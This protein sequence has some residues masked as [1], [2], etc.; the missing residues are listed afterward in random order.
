MFVLEQ[1]GTIRVF[2]TDTP[3]TSSTEFLNIT[4][5]VRSGGELGLLGFAFDP[6]YAANGYVYVNYTAANPLRTVIARF[7]ASDTQP[8]RAD[9]ASRTVILE[10]AQ[11][12]SNHNGGALAF[13]PDGYLYIATGD[14]GSGGDPQRFGQNLNT[15]LG[16]ILRIDVRRPPA[17]IPNDNPFANQLNKRGEIWLYGLRNPWRF[18]FD[19]QTGD[20]WIGD[21]GQNAWEEVDVIPAGTRGTNLGWNTCEGA[22]AY[23]NVRQPCTTGLL[24]I[25]EYDHSVGSSVIGGYVYRGGLFPQLQ[26]QYLFSDFYTREIWALSYNRRFEKTGHARIASMPSGYSMSS[27]GE[28]PRGEI[29]FVGMR[30]SSSKL[31]KLQPRAATPPANFPRKLS[32]TGLFLNT[33][34][35]QPHADLLSYDVNVPLWSDS[36]LK[37][38]WMASL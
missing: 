8:D 9:P 21:V 37:K 28:D 35:L 10:F 29:L 25:H 15:L 7:K 14:G 12:Y 6:H 13:G 22:H 38:R 27:M 23:P 5:S 2:R 33:A 32:Q 17:I 30:S 16:K 1:G 26:G 36:A 19:R 31:F 11:P 18:S 34:E 4:D 20:L 24:P 3:P